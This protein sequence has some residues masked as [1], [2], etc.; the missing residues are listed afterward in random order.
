MNG[1]LVEEMSA[2]G[3][4]FDRDRVGGVVGDLQRGALGDEQMPGHGPERP[5]DDR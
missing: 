4:P 5:P 3:V 2:P 1:A